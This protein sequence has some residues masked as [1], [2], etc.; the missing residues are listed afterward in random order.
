M[1]LA[2]LASGEDTMSI[3][4]RPRPPRA[5]DPSDAEALEA[6]IEEARRRARRRRRGYAACALVAAAAALLVY[7]GFN[8]GGGAT[9]GQVGGEQPS[10][11][12]QNAF[13]RARGWIT[14][15]NGEEIIAVDPANP[16]DTVV[17][18]RFD[19]W[20]AEDPIA[21]S[22]DGTKLLLR[23][24]LE[25]E[26]AIHSPLPGLFI[27]HADGSRTTVLPE[28]ESWG[29]GPPTWGSFSP[30]GTEIAFARNGSS[31]GPYIVA[32][33]GGKRYPLGHRCPRMKIGGRRVEACGEPMFEAAAWS[34]DGSRIAW[35]DFV[36]DSAKFGH[37]ATVLSFVN[38]DGTGLREEVARLP[39]GGGNLVW[40]PDG[41]QLAF[42]GPSQIFVINAD[43]SDLRQITDEGVNQWPAW[44]PDGS[45][46]AFVHDGT[47]YTIAP[48]G[49]AARRLD[50]VTPDGAIAWNPLAIRT[51]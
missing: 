34:P 29:R 49:T 4:T 23:S 11:G 50:G 8:H 10:V 48:D 21:W 27:L 38:P 15:R 24:E 30:D 44:S 35:V 19:F 14:F 2:I 51:S 17:L 28:T 13:A 36:E 22:S 26:G 40:S 7:F 12:A 41:S 39:G 43:G 45:R 18:R 3:L 16:T 9:R 47:L 42:W 31:R 46:I 25:L 33:E 6:L 1:V 20:K 5:D 37:H 32:S